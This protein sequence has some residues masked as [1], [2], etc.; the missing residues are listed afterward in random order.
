[1]RKRPLLIVL[2]LLVALALA[3]WCTDRWLK[4]KDHPGLRTF[5]GQV[6]RNYP[7]S[8]GVEPPVIRLTIG[9]DA[10]ERVQAVVDAARERG[11]IMPEGN[12]YVQGEV[13][14]PEGSWK[15]RLRIKGKMSDHV[16]GDKWSFRVIARKDG[17][18]LG[19]KRFSLQHPGT[20][21]Y[22]AEWFHH[23][24]MRGEGIVALRYGFCRVEL[25]G[26]DLGVYAYEEHFG[27]ELVENN[28][29]PEGPLVRFDPG[30]F[31]QHRL[32]GVEGLGYEDGYGDEQAAN[33]DAFGTGDLKED[34][35]ANRVFE[36]AMTLMEAFR[37]G[38]LAPS[39]VFDVV[40]TG[41][42]LAML[43]LLGGHRSLDWSDV[44][45]YFDPLAQRFE[46]VSYESVSGF[47]IKE[48]AGAF[49]V[50]GPPS[51]TNEFHTALLK[52]T[53]I[54][55]AYVQAL[56]RFSRK[57]WLDST[58][59]ALA[60][61]LDTASATLY[62]EFP[63]KE[64]D[65]GVYY[66]NQRIMQRAM[67]LPK[68]FHAYRE[69]R[70]GDTLRFTVMAVN[71]LPVVVDSLRLIDG[72]AAGVLGADL[73]YARAPGRPGIPQT[74]RFVLP[75]ATD[76]LLD[77]AVISAHL[78]GART[79]VNSEVFHQALVPFDAADFPLSTAPNAGGFPF[80]HIDTETRTIT[81]APGRWSVD[82][83]LVLP[84]GYTWQAAAPLEL[85]LAPGVRIV[86]RSALQWSGQEDLPIR[87][88]SAGGR[89]SLLVLEAGSS[90][91]Q[92]V[93]FQGLAGDGQAAVTFH[94]TPVELVH[95][96]FKGEKGTLLT[97]A[98]TEGTL[99]DCTFNGGKDQ[100]RGRYAKLDLERVGA[101]G[102]KDDAF[103]LEGGS[104][105]IRNSSITGAGGIG[106]K[107]VLGARA[108]LTGCTIE[109]AGTGVEAEEAAYLR[110][111][112]GR[113]A[114]PRTVHAGK[115]EVRYGPV[116]V[117]L[118][119]VALPKD[120]GAMKAGNG[121]TITVNGQAVAVTAKATVE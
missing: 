87:V 76:S 15:A 10:M 65:R 90:R 58:F 112:G 46:P 25:N 68:G 7:K 20:R 29:R 30:L 16:E 64:L 95:C 80:L 83:D 103:T 3:G 21:N 116:L 24:L 79:R 70:S 45:F 63:Y 22:L 73:V 69:G 1:M 38:Q 11:V 41:R 118:D 107:L 106:T 12:D 120:G 50:T 109:A 49:R 35:K 48:I 93:Q 78:P 4:R 6:W 60:G 33:L 2:A 9:D 105:R 40:R 13:T 53:A 71:N 119:K 84:A 92:H 114:A 100:L 31:W 36:Q 104:L 19:M 52:D 5:A 99:R 43:D 88:V 47:P 37:T 51:T 57:E 42:R 28:G 61:A 34:P 97:V 56:E 72:R 62:A 18:F 23:R 67:E 110:M 101:A 55:A 115:A 121:S 17:G 85:V 44:K 81:T 27:P 26:E 113:I 8:F 82:R 98:S 66:R 59:T 86:S 108:E 102:A 54:F 111:Q 74:L 32:N 91:L 94:R 39:K 96:A 75:G 117:D 89:S 77:E 14:S